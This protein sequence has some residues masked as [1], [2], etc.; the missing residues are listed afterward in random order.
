MPNPTGELTPYAEIVAVLDGLSLILRET[1]RQRRLSV[2]AAA[3]EI[4]CSFSTVSRI[5]GGQDCALSNAAAV[6]LWVG[7]GPGA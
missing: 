7:R 4:G 2:R 6:L 5:E 3:V 1:R